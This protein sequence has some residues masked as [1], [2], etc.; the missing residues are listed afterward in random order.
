MVQA[1]VLGEQAPVLGYLESTEGCQELCPGFQEDAEWGGTV[2]PPDHPQGI[3]PPGPSEEGKRGRKSRFNQMAEVFLMAPCG[4]WSWRGG[5]AELQ[6][7]HRKALDLS[8]SLHL[9]EGERSGPKRS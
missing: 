9:W 8:S 4:A 1:D 6:S 3:P 2:H 7:L 5:G